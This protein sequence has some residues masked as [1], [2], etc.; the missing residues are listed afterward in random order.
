MCSTQLRH[1]AVK[2]KR[3]EEYAFGKDF[4]FKFGEYGSS[5]LLHACLS[6]KLLYVN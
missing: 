1:F 6:S 5:H 3:G 2:Q 4:C